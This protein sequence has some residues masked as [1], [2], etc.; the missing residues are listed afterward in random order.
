M[1]RMN[2]RIGEMLGF[3]VIFGEVYNVLLYNYSLISLLES[4]LKSLMIP[5]ASAP[6]IEWG[7]FLLRYSLM[8]LLI[9]IVVYFVYK[10]IHAEE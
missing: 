10:A 6:E 8:Y 1:D 5:G 3:C 2:I 4:M 7:S 9:P